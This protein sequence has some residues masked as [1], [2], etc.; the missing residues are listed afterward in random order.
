MWKTLA[1]MLVAMSLIP[2]GDTAG[3]LLT[4]NHDTSALYVAW[5]RFALGSL[6][7]LPFVRSDVWRLMADWRIW[8]RAGLLVGGI[9]SIQTA[10]L[11]APLADVFAAFFVGPIVSYLLSILLLGERTD[12][13]RGLLMCLGFGGVLLVVRPGFDM[14]AG[15]LWAALA[16]TCYGAFLTASRWVANSASHGSLLV[17]QLGLGTLILSPFALSDIPQLTTPI[18]GLTFASA[19]FSAGANLLLLVAYARAEAAKLAPLAYLQLF[20]AVFLGWLVFAQLPDAFTW[21]GLAFIITAGV[22]SAL[23]PPLKSGA[24]PRSGSQQ[25]HS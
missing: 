16:G 15:L 9:T 25:S 18:A 14:S 6:L 8:L 24:Q 7:A 17:T 1:L 22:V 3:K 21:I 19:A 5:S 23:L 10:L 12:L 2:A 20:S 13:K 4:Q 11:S